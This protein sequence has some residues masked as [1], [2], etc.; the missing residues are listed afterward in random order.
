MVSTSEGGIPEAVLNNETGFVIEPKNVNQLAD[1]LM[2][3]IKD[4]DLRE[5]MGRR[6]KDRFNNNYTLQH[7]EQNIKNVFDKIITTSCI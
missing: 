4:K 6:G 2:L 5:E 3:L 7:F 1:K